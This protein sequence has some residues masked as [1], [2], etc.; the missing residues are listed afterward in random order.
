MSIFDLSLV[1]LFALISCVVIPWFHDS[2]LAP[3]DILLKF[4]LLLTTSIYLWRS[5]PAGRIQISKWVVTCIV[6][7]L[8]SVVTSLP[9]TKQPNMALSAA[10]TIFCSIVWV[11]FLRSRVGTSKICQTLIQSAV[12][13]GL[14]QTALGGYQTR[15]LFHPTLFLSAINKLA[16]TGTFGNPDYVASWLSMC[17]ILTLYGR[18]TLGLSKKSD[19]AVSFALASGLLLT[20]CRGAWLSVLMAVV[21]LEL[22]REAHREYL[23]KRTLSIL[24]L[25]FSL[26]VVIIFKLKGASGLTGLMSLHT[27]R[28]RWLIWA[29]GLRTFWASKGFGI[30][31]D[32]FQFHYF[33]AQ[34]ALF[35]TGRWKQFEVNASMVKRVHNE[36][37]DFL[38]E[39][40][41]FLLA[42]WLLFLTVLVKT[43][44]K[45]R[46][47]AES[48]PFAGFVFYIS[49]V[50]LVSFPLHIVPNLLLGGIA[51]ARLL[52]LRDESSRIELPV[53]P[54][55]VRRLIPLICLALSLSQVRAGLF[56]MFFHRAEAALQN[57]QY[58]VSEADEKKAEKYSPHDY[59]LALLH[60]RLLYRR[61]KSREALKEIVKLEEVGN[62]I[63]LLKLKGLILFDLEDWPKAEEVYR[64]LSIAYPLHITPHYQL[65]RIY[66]RLKEPQKAR[67][68]FVKTL[69]LQP[70]SAK[71]KREQDQAKSLLEDLNEGL[72]GREPL[73]TD[74]AEFF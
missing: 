33:D 27:L 28:G 22:M 58:L 17:L 63:D 6:L 10:E 38:V 44:W 56:Q 53:N 46:G 26:V 3:K 73:A 11:A 47:N 14:F 23:K 19:V 37:L 45:E 4:G 69:T 18:K 29:C 70:L 7:I 68:E 35:E 12:I 64:D 31:L 74:S 40:G 13:I 24:L 5:K 39:G 57:E 50:S 65:G 9:F 34:K 55:I 52:A 42:A 48:L 60:T 36:Y 43:V 41:V 2:F 15:I 51:F 16:F 32:N 62:S 54:L 30:G 49:I 61:F 71:A 25:V 59:E 72:R 20:R 66:I 8:L 21:L 1:S 67:E